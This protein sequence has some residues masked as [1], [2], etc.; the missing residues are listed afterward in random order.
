[1][2][3]FMVKSILSIEFLVNVLYYVCVFLV[4]VFL[5]A[6]IVDCWMIVGERWYMLYLV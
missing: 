3:V 2:F 1:M 4:Y 5:Y 6:N